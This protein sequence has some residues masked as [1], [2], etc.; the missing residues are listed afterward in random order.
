MT[1]IGQLVQLSK[2]GVFYTE[3]VLRV[4]EVQDLLH[5]NE[6]FDLVLMEDFVNE[7]MAIFQHKFKCPSVILTAGPPT[8][9]TNH[10]F[11]NPSQPAYVPNLLNDFGS[12]MTLWERLLNVFHEI[13]GEL[14]VHF[15]NIPNQNE[16]L[17]RILPGAPD[18]KSIL[19]NSSFLLLLSHIS[20]RDP[21]PLQPNVKEIG[22]YHILPTKLLPKDLQEFLDG[23][24]EGAIVFSMGSNLKSADFPQE[25]T[26]AIL[27]VFSRLKQKVLW[28]YETDL[29]GKPANVKIMSWIPQQDVLGI[30][31]FLSQ[32]SKK[33]R[34]NPFVYIL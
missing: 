20:L 12:H 25:K 33:T 30:S 28:K 11:A 21:A 15:V 24:R 16:I 9:F 17:Q 29:P 4:K 2:K 1:Y 13:V 19:Y 10:R 22:G 32:K 8:I 5:S 6:Q 14:Y 31:K 23:A 3:K 7:A 18:V 27:K 26:E 34:R